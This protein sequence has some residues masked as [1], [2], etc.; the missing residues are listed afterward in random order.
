MS[1]Q[2]RFKNNKTSLLVNEELPNFV[3][4]DHPVFI[5][6]LE[7]YY[8][9]L[10]QDDK[11]L[12][13][14]KNLLDLADIDLTPD[15]F[16]SHLYSTFMQYIPSNIK[17]DK[18]LLLKNI[19]DFYRAK[20]TEKSIAFL[21]RALWNAET[22][23]YYPKTDILRVSDGKWYIQKSLR[24]KDTAI[25]GAPN[26]NISG[27]EKYVGTRIAGTF[28][29]THAIVEKVERFYQKGVVIDEIVLSNIDADFVNGEGIIALFDDETQANSTSVITSNIFSGIINTITVTDGG[30]NYHVGDPA[31]IVSSVGDGAV[32]TVSQVSTG[33]IIS[34]GVTSGGAG[35]RLS[36]NVLII[37][38]GT[39]AAASIDQIDTSGYY[40]PNTYNIGGT[41]LAELANT[42]LSNVAN[43]WIQNLSTTWTYANTGPI[44]H[45]LVI[46][47]GENYTSPPA[48][49]VVP[50]T[51]VQSLGILGRMDIIN[52]GQ[53]Y[54]IGD[55]I[56]FDLVPGSVG[57]GASANVTN[58]DSSRA[59][60][61]SEVHWV[62]VPGHF[63]GGEG[64][65]YPLPIPRVVSNTGNGANIV[66]SATLGSGAVLQADRSSIGS[67]QRISIIQPG[68][69]YDQNT[70]IDL[71]GSGDGNAKAS[72]SVIE[73][74]IT[75]PGRWLNDDGQLSSYNFLEDRDYYQNF[76]YVVRANTS[77][78]SYRSTLKALTHPAGTKL[79]GEY[80]H[81]YDATEADANLD[82]ITSETIWLHAPFVKTENVINISTSTYYTRY[83]RAHQGEQFFIDVSDTGNANATPSGSYL[84]SNISP[85][86]VLAVSTIAGNT[87]GNVDFTPRYA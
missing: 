51:Q 14:S 17:V 20:G 86:Y 30:V 81:Y 45:V 12:N 5:T 74:L 67:I 56:E 23:F 35:F 42:V 6:F 79:W 78:N 16:A 57:T 66:V 22:D 28:S 59:N 37:G 15:E 80:I 29:N 25:N 26:T 13:R 8:A 31:L 33:N 65:T 43:S 41:T 19:K 82:P 49:S 71:T 76:S 60:A 3:R 83:G 40:H 24:V 34:V 2:A 53:N 85:N 63:I 11:L 70:T 58:V 21:L 38:S 52:G 55:R 75:Y 68:Q 77:I 39:G 36:D 73:G 46:N 4:R 10:E 50:N 47:H 1:N 62:Q 27:L 48:L 44:G 32:A 18:K 9:Y 64:Y 7:K 87:S 69:N 72:V 61:I 54:H 84:V